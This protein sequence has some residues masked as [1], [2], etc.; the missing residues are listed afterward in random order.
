M[1]KKYLSIFIFCEHF[2]TVSFSLDSSPCAFADA[3][4]GSLQD[5]LEEVEVSSLQGLL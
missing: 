5:Y 1:S 3:E 4:L 2:L